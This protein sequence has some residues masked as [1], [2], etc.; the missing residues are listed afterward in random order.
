MLFKHFSCLQKEENLIDD[1]FEKLD[2]GVVEVVE[3]DFDLTLPSKK[4]KKKKKVQIL[5]EEEPEEATGMNNEC[6]PITQF[7]MEQPL[8]YSQHDHCILPTLSPHTTTRS[9]HTTT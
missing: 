6:S 3:G 9:P 7:E 5:D 8:R 1:N 4:K 2:E